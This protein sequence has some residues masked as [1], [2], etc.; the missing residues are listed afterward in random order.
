MRCGILIEARFLCVGNPNYTCLHAPLHNK[1]MHCA[2]QLH[3]ISFIDVG[4]AATLRGYIIYAYEVSTSA[5]AW[6]LLLGWATTK[7]YHS[8]LRFDRR[9]S[10]YYGVS[11]N[12]YNN[13]NNNAAMDTIKRNINTH[14]FRFPPAI[15]HLLPVYSRRPTFIIAFTK[16]EFII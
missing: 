16:F 10:T 11:T 1:T 2:L 5:L 7:E 9:R 8:R 3:S 14:Y 13:N 12:V 15:D 4:V 6:R